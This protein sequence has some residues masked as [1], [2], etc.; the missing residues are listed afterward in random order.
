MASWSFLIV[1]LYDFHFPYKYENVI[2]LVRGENPLPDAHRDD[3]AFAQLMHKK[4]LAYLPAV[5]GSNAEDMSQPLTQL[6]VNAE[7]V[8]TEK[9]FRIVFDEPVSGEE[10]GMIGFNGLHA[11]EEEVSVTMMMESELSPDGTVAF[12]FCLKGDSYLIPVC[13]SPYV[14][15]Q[16]K[17]DYVE[18]TSDAWEKISA[19]E[20]EVCLYQ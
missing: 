4:N 13:T 15:Q 8:T 9:G 14:S 11:E 5:W 18:L 17:I 1:I 16:E 2:Y 7:A 20:I 10:L 12:E 6:S 3:E 19:D